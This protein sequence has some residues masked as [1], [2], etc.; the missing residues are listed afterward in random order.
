MAQNTAAVNSE[1]KAYTSPS[2][3]ENQNESLKAYASAP[4]AEAPSTA[5]W[6]PWVK[7]S[8]LKNLRAK[9]E[10][11]QNKKSTVKEL[12]SALS[13]LMARASLPSPKKI[14]NRREINIHSGAP[15]G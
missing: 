12:A 11:D 1:D 8:L 3:A 15:G 7:V 9:C 10:T 6:A 5:T 14:T 4:T 2:T 13:T